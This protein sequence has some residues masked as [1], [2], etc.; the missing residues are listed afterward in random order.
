VTDR[1][2]NYAR[3]RRF[4]VREASF[5]EDTRQATDLVVFTTVGLPREQSFACRVRSR[6]YWDKYPNDVTIRYAQADGRGAEW[7]KIQRGWGDWFIYG[8]TDPARP[9]RLAQW[10]VIN[11]HMFRPLMEAHRFE[12]GNNAADNGGESFKI[13]PLDYLTPFLG[14]VVQ[15]HG[16]P[17]TQQQLGFNFWENA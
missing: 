6:Q 1:L 9:G 8:F 5:L 16:F 15:R 3:R 17:A 4:R 12:T 13:V 2:N 10:S 7:H 14:T 11:L